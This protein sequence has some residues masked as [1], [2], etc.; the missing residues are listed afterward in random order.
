MKNKNVE[1]VL[2]MEREK[3]VSLLEYSDAL[4]SLTPEELDEL[5]IIQ[6]AEFFKKYPKAKASIAETVKALRDCEE[7]D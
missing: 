2:M 5:K 7:E 4:D 6:D 3:K 1:K